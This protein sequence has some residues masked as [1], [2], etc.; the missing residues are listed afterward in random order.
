MVLKKDRGL[1]PHRKNNNINHPVDKTTKQR[2]YVEQRMATSGINGK[3]GPWSCDALMPQTRGM[4]R[5]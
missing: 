4:P 1:Q 2:V 3:R 5:W